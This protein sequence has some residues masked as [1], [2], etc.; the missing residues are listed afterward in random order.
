[1]ATGEA[2]INKGDATTENDSQ[3]LSLLRALQTGQDQLRTSLT[4]EMNNM[5]RELKGMIDKKFTDLRKK[6]DADM[7]AMSSDISRVADRV[8]E[9]E[10]SRNNDMQQMDN[11][12][13]NKMIF[14]KNLPDIPEET[15]DKILETFNSIVTAMGLELGVVRAIKAERVNRGIPGKPKSVLVTLENQQM[16]SMVMKNKRKLR[17]GGVI[18]PIMTCLLTHGSANKIDFFRP[19]YGILLRLF[20]H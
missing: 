12:Q 11:A 13:G 16:R 15:P 7:K 19:T 1:M 2:L 18:Y 17:G 14:I 8:K 20:P 5:K 10:Q 9:L 3:V 4:E 6:V